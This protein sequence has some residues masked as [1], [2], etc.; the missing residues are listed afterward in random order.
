MRVLYLVPDLFGPPGGIARY[1]R[2]VCRALSGTECELT[3]IALLDQN[4]ARR[5]ARRAFPALKYLPCGGRRMRF[6]RNALRAAR[7]R[8]D[9][10]FVGHPHFA[11]LGWLLAKICRARLVT[12][13][14]GVDAWKPLSPARRR[15]LGASHQIISISRFTASQAAQNNGIRLEK[16]RLLPNC[17]D[18]ALS[19]SGFLP[20]EKGWNGTSKTATSP[21]LLTVS[22]ILKS[23][24]HKGH[25][26]VIRALP[27]LLQ[28][29]PTLVYNVVGDGEGR[30]E[31]EALARQLGVSDAVHFHGVVSDEEMLDF[32]AGA[33]VFI[34]P[35]SREGFGFVFIEAMMQGV[36]AIGGNRDATPEVIVDGETG[37]L[38]DPTSVPSIAQASAQLLGDT[39]LRHR[40]GQ[41][42]LLH[43][44]REF[45]FEK[46][47][48][49]LLSHLSEL[50]VLCCVLFAAV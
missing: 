31:M 21:S 32:Y 22:R 10:I 5:D 36:P 3:V 34:M 19:P 7:A 48:T 20:I 16:A 6:V 42:A 40:M 4:S 25:D 13:I 18:P 35:S 33:D 44:E 46:F 26:Q 9:V 47:K 27:E 45:N 11:P 39:A 41:A 37:F 14:Y 24:M 30:P 29:F 2:M 38:V 15:A 17:V 8:P 1:C 50:G 43:V 12:F 23:E 28:Q 49:T